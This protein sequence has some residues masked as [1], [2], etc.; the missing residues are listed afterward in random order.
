MNVIESAGQAVSR[1]NATQTAPQIASRHLA[2]GV[3]CSILFT[4]IF[5][6]LFD[7][8]ADHGKTVTPWGRRR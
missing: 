7:F 2:L 6:R 1:A 5:A 8:V 3:V 4:V